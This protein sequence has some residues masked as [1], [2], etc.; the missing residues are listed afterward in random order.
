MNN[1]VLILGS[2]GMLGS[3]VSRYFL[4]NKDLDVRTTSRIPIGENEYYFDVKDPKN[5]DAMKYILDEFKP[6]VII[7][8]IGAIPQSGKN[9]HRE[10]FDINYQFPYRLAVNSDAYLIQPS[11]DCVFSGIPKVPGKVNISKNS[12]FIEETA[13]DLEK[14]DFGVSSDAYRDSKRLF[15]Y[16]VAT[17][18][19]IYRRVI[20]LR[21][22]LIGP[23][24]ESKVGGG[25]LFDFVRSNRG[26]K[27]K[28]Y[29]N[30]FWN[31]NTTLEFAELCEDMILDYHSSFTGIISLGNPKV[32]SKY[33]LIRLIKE[34]FQFDIELEEFATPNTVDKSITND[35][36]DVDSIEIQLRR[37][38]QWITE[39]GIK[40]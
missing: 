27:I 3:V 33:E 19:D 2:T 37:L 11:T 16:G 21:G 26:N 32:V 12:E 36:I 35:V 40:L 10:F 28:G 39:Q 23:N 24:V 15:D 29:T 7:N 31:G 9:T 38:K 5:F 30:H 6:G 22:S 20:V 34:I 4:N 17:N 25:G 18:P 13:N 14:Y 8:C 1:K